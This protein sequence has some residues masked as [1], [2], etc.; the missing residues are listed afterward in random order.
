MRKAKI[1]EL[2]TCH[3]QIYCLDVLMVLRWNCPKINKCR[4]RL[5]LNFPI[6]PQTGFLKGTLSGRLSNWERL[7][8]VLKETRHVY[9]TYTKL[10][11]ATALLRS[12]KGL[13][14]FPPTHSLPACPPS[15]SLLFLMMMDYKLPLRWPST[16]FP[17][18]LTV[19][20]MWHTWMASLLFSAYS[21]PHRPSCFQRR[22]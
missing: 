14:V 1:K 7:I 10:S 16:G 17:F 19:V 18:D 8:L 15:P 4:E 22:N 12:S 13:F 5:S 21:L 2:G 6:C 9:H 11:Q 20:F 3:P